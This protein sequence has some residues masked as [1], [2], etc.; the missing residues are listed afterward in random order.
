MHADFLPGARIDELPEVE[1]PRT[2]A[3][4]DEG[5]VVLPD[6]GVFGDG[7]G[8]DRFANAQAF[9]APPAAVRGFL[10][11]RRETVAIESVTDPFR[12][13]AWKRIV[14]EKGPSRRITLEEF[15]RELLHE[16]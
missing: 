11:R 8:T 12:G 16:A 7:G 4:G 2:L 13:F 5:I 1:R 10:R 14:S 6:S 9:A 3:R 15:L